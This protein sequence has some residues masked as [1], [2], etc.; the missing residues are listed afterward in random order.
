MAQLP[1]QRIS[2]RRKTQ[3]WAIDSAKHF[4][5]NTNFNTREKTQMKEL[6]RAYNSYLDES[7]FKYITNPFGAPAHKKLSWPAKMRNYNILRPVIDMMLGEKLVRKDSYT[8]TVSNP[9]AVSG[10]QKAL[11]QK[12]VEN[13][14]QMFINELNEMGVDT[15]VQT[16]Q[17]LDP[18]KL[19]AKLSTSWPDQRAIMG[20]Q[21]V[22]YLTDFLDL[23]DRWLNGFLDFMIAGEVCS[24]KEPFRDDIEYEVFPPTEL[25]YHHSPNLDFIEDGQWAVRKQHMQMNGVID[26]FREELN[27]DQIG[28][29]ETAGGS[30]PGVPVDDMFAPFWS[31]Q[32][33]QFDILIPVE[34]VVWKSLKKIGKLVVRSEVGT[35]VEE[36]SSSYVPEPGEE[37]TWEWITEVWQIHRI[38]GT[39]YTKAAPL[40]WDRSKVN[41]SSDQKLP[42][43]GRAYSNRNATNTSIALN[44]MPFQALYNILHWKFEL[45]I[46]KNKDSIILMDINAVPKKPGWDE[47]KFIYYADA[48]GFMWVDNSNPKSRGFN[49]Y[50]VLNSTLGAYV[51][52]LAELMAATKQEWEESLG[53][54]RQRKGQQ[55]ASDL[56]SVTEQAVTR[57]AIVTADLFRKYEK[58]QQREIQG[59]LDIS[60]YAWAEGKKAMYISSDMRR[61]ILDI[62]P[63]VFMEADLGVFAKNTA[64]EKEKL[65]AMKNLT[66]QFSQN[67]VGPR[68]IAEV[69]DADSFPQLK[70]K[71]SEIEILEGQM[72]EAQQQAEQQA[73]L[74]DAQIKEQSEDMERQ[75]ESRESALQRAH[76]F[77]LKLLEG[78]ISGTGVDVG[79]IEKN[80]LERQKDL[81]QTFLKQSEI[82]IKKDANRIKEK[83]VD[84]E[85]ILREKE[86]KV[87]LANPVAGEK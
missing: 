58:F 31:R 86:M 59:L 5:S 23:K 56:K 51:K 54:N 55:F 30:G 74:Q 26:K 53:I 16:D 39:I 78:E 66:F 41:N 28:E 84:N 10:Y 20:Q 38:N 22:N 63:E 68:T 17:V 24:Y 44:G 9:D 48:H 60:K 57:S 37:I 8:V 85:K 87:A 75:H 67:K 19:E 43:N 47:D 35:T 33:G 79:A 42:Y 1:Q 15:G 72:A 11:S 83:Q 18:A 36:V 69:L 80:A 21:A 27:A 73:A 13:L 64:E 4:L 71:L 45:S 6:Y 50:Q 61:A 70:E 62:T 65:D 2:R 25:D 7:Q 3:Q 81:N 14:Q 34:H 49:Q 12:S 46:A 76:E 32:R 52:V 40:D 29:L 77:Q 82:D